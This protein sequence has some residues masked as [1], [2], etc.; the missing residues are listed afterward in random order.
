[1]PGKMPKLADISPA[2]DR[3]VTQ[4]AA[5]D[6]DNPPLT[7]EEL[8]RFRPVAEV[9]PD[10]AKAHLQSRKRRK[11][12]E[13]VVRGQPLTLRLDPEVVAF[14]KATGRNWQARINTV[15]KAY[16][17]QRIRRGRSGVPFR[18]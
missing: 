16:V 7:S 11:R 5:L 14:F 9:M 15:L 6:P 4:A 2:E 17:R 12:P 13:P 18:R 1:M 8:S 3:R 10:L